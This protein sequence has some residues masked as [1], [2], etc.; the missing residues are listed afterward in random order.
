MMRTR[1][2]AWRET[3][4]LTQEAAARKLGMSSALLRL[5]E[6]GRGRPSSRIAGRLQRYFGEETE[7]L[8]KPATIVDVPTR[9]RVPA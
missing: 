5:L 2:W 3:A 4:A 1:L 7:Q 6:S 9:G 8:L